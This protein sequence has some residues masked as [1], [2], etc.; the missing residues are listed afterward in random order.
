[1]FKKGKKVQN[2]DIYERIN[3]LAEA[4]KIAASN[5]DLITLSQYLG[6]EADL[7]AK[8]SNIRTKPKKTLCKKCHTP[9]LLNT[10]AEVS[11]GPE[12]TE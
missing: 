12:Y 5:P 3:F 9:L 6:S 2:Q 7:T 8:R 10:T 11:I 4:A 1:M